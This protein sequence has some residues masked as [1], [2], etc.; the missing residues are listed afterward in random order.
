MSRAQ[1][2]EKKVFVDHFNH[3]KSTILRTIKTLSVFM[4]SKTALHE[5]KSQRTQQLNAVASAPFGE[6]LHLI[7]KLSESTKHLLRDA[8]LV[9]H[10]QQSANVIIVNDKRKSCR[11]IMK[12]VVD[13]W[14]AHAA[15]KWPGE[16][17]NELFNKLIEINAAF[18]TEMKHLRDGVDAMRK[19]LTTTLSSKDFAKKLGEEAV[20][21]RLAEIRAAPPSPTP[22]RR[23]P[24]KAK[25][26]ASDDDD[27]NDE[28]DEAEDLGDQDSIV[29]NEEEDD[30][31]DV[32]DGFIVHSKSKKRDRPMSTY[33]DEKLARD[34][35]AETSSEDVA[36]NEAL[37]LAVAKKIKTRHQPARRSAAIQKL[38]DEQTAADAAYQ[39]DFLKRQARIEALR[40]ADAMGEP[41][42][43][44]EVANIEY[45]DP[46]D[47]EPDFDIEKS[48]KPDTE[49]GAAAGD[50]DKQPDENG[51]PD[52]GAVA[53]D[54]VA[55]AGDSTGAAVD[56]AA[57]ADTEAADAEPTADEAAEDDF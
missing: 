46:D 56:D 9:G 33:V 51:E 11:E 50:G 14:E 23:A 29:D 55:A 18:V 57:P 19:D 44:E 10:N 43:E 25:T 22:T 40:L 42:T 5:K 41:E 24:G 45:V 49:N 17:K 34:E 32:D 35:D 48:Q 1:A 54:E 27:D 28:E 8:L 6:K 21:A 4:A 36:A 7:D 3:A 30:G 39:E 53:E 37:N 13:A 15:A 52:A 47:E 12:P 38:Y 26:D 16:T 31:P 2:A 20:K